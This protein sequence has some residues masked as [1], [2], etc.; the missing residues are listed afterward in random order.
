MKKAKKPI[1]IIVGIILFG[2]SLIS[3][4]VAQEKGYKALLGE[5]DAQTEDG[6]Y[7]FVFVFSMEG[8]T[9]KGIFQGMTGDVEM[10]NLSFEE[11]ELTFTVT[12]DA[13]GQSMVID[14]EAT[15]EGDSLEGFLSMEYGEANI[16][17]K[18]RK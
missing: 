16:T 4:A 18:K 17:G 5:W 7:T 11:N 14:F 13:G 12:L 9:L 8:E 1:L 15:V 10:E 2:L 6:Q 3:S